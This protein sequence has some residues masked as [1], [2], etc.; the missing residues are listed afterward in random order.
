M[1]DT[2]KVVPSFHQMVGFHFLVTFEKLP[3][4][5]NL[6]VSF[7]SVSGL[8]VQMDTETWK[9]GGENRFEHT[10]PS[11]SK[12][13]STL[14]LKRG[15]LKPGQSGLSNWCINSFVHLKIVPLETV[16]VQLLDENHNAL[17]VWNLAHVWPKSWKIAEFNAERSEVLIETLELNFN[18]FSLQNA[19]SNANRN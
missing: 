10:L 12:F 3:N 16:N 14:T 7:Q 6:D 15:L 8:D 1:S 9:E 19:N 17:L 18:R 11:R 2:T 4:A 13:S 5:G